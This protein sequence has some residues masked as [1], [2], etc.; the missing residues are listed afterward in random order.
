M[1]IF[2]RLSLEELDTIRIEKLQPTHDTLVAIL[3][4]MLHGF[5][6][7]YKYEDLKNSFSTYDYYGIKDTEGY[8]IISVKIVITKDQKD[9]IKK[10]IKS[11]KYAIISGLVSR[12]KGRGTLLMNYVIDKYS[13]YPLYLTARTK[14]LIPYYEKFGFESIETDKKNHHPMV[15]K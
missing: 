3:D 14:S 15:R 8:S 5:G 2:R 4:T 10:V 11:Y 13:N 6:T 1:S 9:Y 12:K 7:S